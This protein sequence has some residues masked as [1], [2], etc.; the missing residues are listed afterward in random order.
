VHLPDSNRSP[1]KVTPPAYVH[2]PGSPSP[3]PTLEGR[4]EAVGPR[5]AVKILA[6][7]LLMTSVGRDGAS[8][9]RGGSSG[10]GG[11]STGI[12]DGSNYGLLA[13]FTPSD[14]TPEESTAKRVNGT[15]SPS[16]STSSS[17]L[18]PDRVDNT[19]A[20]SD[21]SL[22]VATRPTR[23]GQVAVMWSILQDQRL[24]RDTAYLTK[25]LL[26]RLTCN[27]NRLED[28]H[29]ELSNRR[30]ITRAILVIS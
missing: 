26:V 6:Q 21:S 23:N 16:S 17:R 28:T 15:P 20:V 4:E 10:G 18:R 3:S 12:G 29:C 11:Y 27:A 19:S 22:A 14:P 5:D 24:V 13:P 7:R 2:G 25:L 8:V 30:T 1:E 9:P